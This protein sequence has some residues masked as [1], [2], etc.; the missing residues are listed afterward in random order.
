MSNNSSNGGMQIFHGSGGS[1]NGPVSQA[2]AQS[3]DG[4]VLDFYIIGGIAIAILLISLI[5]LSAIRILKKSM[6][7]TT[8]KK[9]NQENHV[10]ANDFTADDLIFDEDQDESNELGLTEDGQYIFRDGTWY[11]Y[12]DGEVVVYDSEEFEAY[13][14][15][16][17]D[18]VETQDALVESVM[19]D[20]KYQD[21]LLKDDDDKD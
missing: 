12:I 9:N 16:Q 20:V 3:T 1:A 18:D 8:Q 17:F 14:R 7:N 15:R 19:G 10:L 13:L 2:I 5:F 11:V 21:N 4:W 6:L